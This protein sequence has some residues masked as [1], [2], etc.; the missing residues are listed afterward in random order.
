M[1]TQLLAA[2]NTDMTSS[3]TPP[4]SLESSG[5]KI[6]G[7]IHQYIDNV[8]CEMGS[9]RLASI[10]KNLRKSAVDSNGS[11]ALTIS[12]CSDLVVQI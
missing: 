7:T 5:D 8:L 4:K 6:Y 2:S 3:S 1:D 10:K 11:V 9:M 12:I